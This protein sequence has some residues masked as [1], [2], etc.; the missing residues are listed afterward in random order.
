MIL[1][2]YDSDDFNKDVYDE[3]KINRDGI[4]L[5][6]VAED[7]DPDDHILL[8]MTKNDGDKKLPKLLK[9]FYE[10]DKN[11]ELKP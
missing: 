4:E 3:I 11:V 7:S 10:V 6:Y 1:R 5:V 2:F 9:I 8:V